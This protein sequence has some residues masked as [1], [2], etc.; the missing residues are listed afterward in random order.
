MAGGI[1][2]R[3][4]DET[5]MCSGILEVGVSQEDCCSF[6]HPTGWSE[7]DDYTESQLF[8]MGFLSDGQPNCHACRR[9]TPKPRPPWLYHVYKFDCCMFYTCT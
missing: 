3:N 7:R 1:C 6:D 4:I 8:Y 9:K 5:G 2:W